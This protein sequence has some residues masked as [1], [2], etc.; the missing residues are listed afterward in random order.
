MKN[1]NKLIEIL[2]DETGRGASLV[3]SRNGD[4]LTAGVVEDGDT[5]LCPAGEMWLMCNGRDSAEDAVAEIEAR[6]AKGFKLQEEWL[7][8]A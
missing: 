4:G 8:Q 5:L 3:V 2:Y 1:I 6:V 7:T